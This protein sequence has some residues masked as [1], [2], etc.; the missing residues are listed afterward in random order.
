MAFVQAYLANP[1]GDYQQEFRLQHKDGTYRWIEARAS[2]V[3]ELDGRRVRL[4][5]SHVDITERKQSEAALRLAKFSVER[6]AD[7]VYWIDSQAKILDVNE[8]ASHMLG[9]SRDELCAMTVHDLNPGFQA[10]MWLGFWAETQRCGTMVVE[11]AHRA[12]NGR[13]IPIE[14]SVNYLSYEGK[15]FHCAFVRDVTE[16]KRAEEVLRESEERLQRAIEASGAGT[17][18]VDFRTGLDTRD[19]GLNRLLGLPPKTTTQ[20]MEDWFTFVHQDDRPVM[21]AAWQAA[22][23][24]N[25]Y[26]SEHRLIR[27][28]GTGCWVYDRGRFVLDEAG[29]LL[30]ATGAVI[31]ITERKRAEEERRKSHT[32][33]RQIIDTDPNLI[34]AKD[35][36]GR[37]VLGNKAVAD[38]YGTTVENLIGKTDAEFNPNQEEVAFF[39]QKD[40]EVMTLR[41]DV[42]LSEERITDAS[43]RARW[44]QTVKRPIFND[45]GRATMVLG[46]STDITERKRMEDALR[47]RER[48]LQAALQ[49]RERISQDLHDGILQSLF[50]VGLNLEVAKSLMPPRT[51]KTSGAITQ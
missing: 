4:V 9:Y 16:R 20:P 36:D 34:F 8:A 6:A 14:V 27:R 50:A 45:E 31:D 21:E 12:K 2:F 22:F 51:R 18:R 13:L 24:T 7:A 25:L 5:G 1:V 3:T 11:T 15:G 33:I 49:E 44:L 28:D 47:T 40:V 32:F 38:V 10:D 17:W 42:F 30:Y 43:G 37:F 39:R 46:A 35:Y 19:A 23:V 26:E 48:E 29:Q 41:Q